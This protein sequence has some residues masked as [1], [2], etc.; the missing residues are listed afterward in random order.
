[1]PAAFVLQNGSNTLSSTLCGDS[2]P[3]IDDAQSDLAAG[4]IGANRKRPCGGIGCSH[5]IG[6]VEDEVE[7][8]LLQLNV[9]G[10]DRR[11]VRG[12]IG[13]RRDMA[14]QQFGAHHFERLA[15]Q[16]IEI[17][18]RHLHVAA[19]VQLAQPAYHIRRATV[20]VG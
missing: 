1:M 17:D 16:F 18:R 13:H 10:I 6:S 14:N 12:E 20:L 7:D 4:S 5:R 19:L 11:Q 3:V 2:H 9:R 8:Q 15:N